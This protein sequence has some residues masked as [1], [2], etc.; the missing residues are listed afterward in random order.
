MKTISKYSYA[1]MKDDFYSKWDILCMCE[2]VIVKI[3]FK[4]LESKVLLWNRGLTSTNANLLLN[5]FL[6]TKKFEYL[7]LNHRLED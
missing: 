5:A 4:V 7:L 1:S 6:N 2:Q 3:H